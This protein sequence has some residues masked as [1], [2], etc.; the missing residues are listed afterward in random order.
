MSV[1]KLKQIPEGFIEDADFYK[2]MPIDTY[3]PVDV[4][5][6]IMFKMVI[7][8]QMEIDNIIATSGLAHRVTNK[9]KADSHQ[10]SLCIVIVAYT[11]RQVVEMIENARRLAGKFIDEGGDFSS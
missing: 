1:S 9:P 5:G 4:G 2:I 3:V 10:K 8:D 11:H 6:R 7:L